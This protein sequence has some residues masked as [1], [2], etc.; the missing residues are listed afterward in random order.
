MDIQARKD[1]LIELIMKVQDS[2]FLG[3]VEALFS[4]KTD[5]ADELTEEQRRGILEA[6]ERVNSGD[7]LSSTEVWNAFDKRFKQK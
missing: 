5:W 3:K 6:R 2:Q 1:H 7:Y 4:A